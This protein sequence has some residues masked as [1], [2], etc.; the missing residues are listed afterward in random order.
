MVSIPTCVALTSSEP[1]WLMEPAITELP[2]FLVTGM[3]SPGITKQQLVRKHEAAE[4]RNRT[5]VAN[6][7]A[8]AETTTQIIT[9]DYMFV[10]TG[11][12]SFHI[13]KGFSD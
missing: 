9:K 8:L 3:A 2:S 7:A 1:F 6:T 5:S 4:H 10:S 12:L 13:L 11:N